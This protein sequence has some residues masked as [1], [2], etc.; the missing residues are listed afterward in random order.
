MDPSQIVVACHSTGSSSRPVYFVFP[1][2]FRSKETKEKL[3]ETLPSK[4]EIKLEVKG[5]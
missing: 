1:P 5:V 2:C 3:T 4:S